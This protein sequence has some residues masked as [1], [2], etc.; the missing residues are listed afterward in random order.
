LTAALFYAF[1]AV[2]IFVGAAGQLGLSPRAATSAFFVVFMT[3]TIS[4][5]L[6][7]LRY[8]QPLPIGF[9]VPGLVL[10]ASASDR[11]SHAEMVGA[12][13][14]VGVAILVLGLLGVGERLLRWLPLPI[15]LG[16]FAGNLLGLVAGVFAHLETEPAAVGAALAGYLG[17]RAVNRTWLPPVAGAV[18]AGIGVAALLGRADPGAFAWAPPVAVP[19]APGFDPLGV[20]ALAVPLLGFSLGLGHVQGIGYLRSQGYDPPV[21]PM[22]LVLG[23]NTL[24]NALFGGPPSTIQANGVAVLGGPEAGPRETRY[25]A[26]LIA[27]ALGT[28]IGLCAATASALLGVIPLALAL[29]LAGLGLVGA[30]MEALRKIAASD[31]SEAGGGLPAGAFFALI[32]AASPLSLLGIGSACWAMVGGLVVSLVLEREALLRRWRGAVE[33]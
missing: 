30:L 3:S 11:Y 29:A 9:T 8:R 27:A 7:T 21:R 26:N 17:A 28:A 12:C 15:V 14:V 20:V 1:G 32:I 31:P 5:A 16:T 24:V 10:L 33:G 18:L 2:P 6:L 19:I 13:L 4:S 23:V 25:V 22:V